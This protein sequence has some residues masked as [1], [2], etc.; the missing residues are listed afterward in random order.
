[1]L[2]GQTFD[3]DYHASDDI[4]ARVCHFKDFHSGK[5][6]H[7]EDCTARYAHAKSVEVYKGRF[8]NVIGD[9]HVSGDHSTVTSLLKAKFV[10][11][12]QCHLNIV[13]AGFGA[14]ITNSTFKVATVADGPLNFSSVERVTAHE[15]RAKDRVI[16][17][18]IELDRLESGS[19]AQ[20]VNSNVVKVVAYNVLCGIDSHIEEAIVHVTE[21]KPQIELYNT[22]VRQVTLIGKEPFTPLFYGTRSFN[23]K[24]VLE[25]PVPATPADLPNR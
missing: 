9:E 23:Y 19:R 3:N 12:D 21:E 7:F 6:V 14:S 20:I 11:A 5:N 2:V 4:V 10:Q 25:N 1:M 24:I 8:A 13:E 16:V 17:S 15:I 18:N 22:E